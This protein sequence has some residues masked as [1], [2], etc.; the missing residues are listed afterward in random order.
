MRFYT[1][2][3]VL[4]V[5]FCILFPASSV[6]AEDVTKPH[7]FSAGT[8]ASA[9]E[10]NANFD[11]LYEEINK[12]RGEIEELKQTNGLPP[13]D[14][15][16]GWFYVEKDEIYNKEHNMGVLPKL[17]VIWG[18]NGGEGDDMFLMDGFSAY[19]SFIRNIT[20]TSYSIAT[21]VS[22][23]MNSG[24]YANCYIKVLMWK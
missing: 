23:A 22:S 17:A 16:S 3:K 24:R 14:Y 21:G 10:V 8:T 4:F 18:A 11:L 6:I 13:A 5:L 1:N 20:T 7:T 19:G 2:F 15:D 9:S 12:L